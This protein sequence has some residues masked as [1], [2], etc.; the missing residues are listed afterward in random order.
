MASITLRAFAK[1][2]LSLRIKDARP[3]GFHEVQTILQAI[4]LFDRVKCEKRR[5]PFQIR[6]D[7]PDVPTDRTNLVWKAAQMLWDTAG[8]GGE[9]RE[10]G[11][12]SCREG[13]GG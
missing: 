10:I 5:G 12:A 9:M 3:D 11:R 4:D 6:C 2:N 7:M 8:R 13:V 1:I